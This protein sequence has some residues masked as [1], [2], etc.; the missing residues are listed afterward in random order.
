[1]RELENGDLLVEGEFETTGVVEDQ[2]GNKWTLPADDKGQDLTFM[3]Q[4]PLAHKKDPRF[5]YEFVR[6]SDVPT[7]QHSEAQFK[8]VSR[9]EAGFGA[10]Q[11]ANL[12]EGG[13]DVQFGPNEAYKLGGGVGE[14]LY[15]M[16]TP[17]EWSKK[18]E[19]AKKS[20]ADA[21]IESCLSQSQSDE[22]KRIREAGLGYEIERNALVGLRVKERKEQPFRTVVED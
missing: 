15:L 11:K 14:P 1:M 5:H 2:F 13:P 17:R 21:T 4:N 8:L 7:Y 10:M 18:I 9:E 16:K 3:L 22:A 19:E 6:A 12:V 20:A